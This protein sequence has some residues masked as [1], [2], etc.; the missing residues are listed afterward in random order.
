MHM[1][2]SESSDGISTMITIN[3]ASFFVSRDHVEYF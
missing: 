2:T 3:E 1:G